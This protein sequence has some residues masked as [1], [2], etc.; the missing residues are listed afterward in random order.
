MNMFGTPRTRMTRLL[1]SAYPNQEHLIV[2]TGLDWKNGDKLA[3]P[4]TNIDTHS[5]ETVIVEDYD[6]ESG[7]V[8]LTEPLRGY[9]FGA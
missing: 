5:S 6:S 8:T 2:D 4:A 3:L 7:L 1:E 9:H